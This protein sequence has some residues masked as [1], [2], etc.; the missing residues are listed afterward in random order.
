MEEPMISTAYKRYVLATLT[1]VVTMNWTDRGL[2]MLLL[3]PIKEDL[4][5]SDT[6]LGFLTGIA[7]ALFYATLGLPIARWADRGN[8]VTITSLAIGLWGLTVMS[9]LAV[10]NFVQL[11]FARVFAAVGE[12]GCMPPTY[13]LVADYFPAPRERTRAMA[14][15][16]LASPVSQIISFIVGSLLQ[17]RL[18]WR[19]TF[20]VMGIPGLLVAGLV[21]LTIAEP[22]ERRVQGYTTLAPV[23]WVLEV[24]SILWRQRTSR[25]LS[26]AIILTLTLSLGLSPWYAAFMV[27]S[28]GMA[29]A[30]LGV[31]LG[32]I[33]GF[34]GIAGTALGGYVAS[35]WFADNERA[36]LRLSAAMIALLAPC[37][38]LFLLLPGQHQA[39]FALAPLFVVFHFFLGPTF[40]LLQRL[41]KEEMCAITLAVVMM[42]SHLIGMGIG[43]LIVGF[44]SDGL[45]PLLG[46]ESLRYAMLAM[47]WVA[48]W[49]AYHFWRAGQSVAIDIPTVYRW[50]DDAIDIFGALPPVAAITPK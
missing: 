37:V 45:H 3:Q 12:A 17:G 18:G 13:S 29:I 44:L 22:R 28:H 48:L 1:F 31:W 7:F 6:Q 30:P 33:F 10:T 9:C 39:L 23:P 11:V 47:S 5:L 43:P 16:W 41:V 38:A 24:L 40:A 21:K 34:G 25:H 20:F 50:N 19:M 26:V 42:L 35:R 46:E 8:R 2:I 14:F 27:R 49:A 4:Q 36:Q 32:L 15:Y